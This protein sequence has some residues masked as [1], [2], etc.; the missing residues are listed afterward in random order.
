MIIEKTVAKKSLA[1]TLALA[2]F[3]SAPMSAWSQTQS[4]ASRAGNGY[5]SL[6]T[7]APAV[8]YAPTISP[9]AHTV[10]LPN[11]SLTS[12]ALTVAPVVQALAAA[13]PRVDI[14]SGS[15]IPLA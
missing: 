9:F 14:V 4:A 8:S 11:F 12:P 1:V 2:L 15:T 13:S 7:V 6:S 3:A 5:G 10:S